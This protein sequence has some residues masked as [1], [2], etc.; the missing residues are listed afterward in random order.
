MEQ[1]VM[2]R[3]EK[4]EGPGNSPNDSTLYLKVKGY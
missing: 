2:V 4:S 1:K 3:D